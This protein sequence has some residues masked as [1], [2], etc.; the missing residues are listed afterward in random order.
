M[1]LNES[2]DPNNKKLMKLQKGDIFIVQPVKGEKENSVVTIVNG[3]EVMFSTSSKDSESRKGYRIYTTDAIEGDIL[4]FFPGKSKTR[5]K[6]QFAYIGVYD[7]NRN[8]K[9]TIQPRPPKEEK[10]EEEEEKLSPEQE[11]VREVLEQERQNIFDDFTDVEEGD[12]FSF[13]F[14]DV[15]KDE[16]GNYTGEYI[17]GTTKQA[18]FKAS[19]IYNEDIVMAKFEKIEGNDT[20][21]LEQYIGQTLSFVMDENGLFNDS[22]VG[23]SMKAF[24]NHEK[25]INFQFVYYFH[26]QKEGTEGED[27]IV[28]PKPK[29]NKDLMRLIHHKTWKDKLFG[30]E[31]KGIIPLEKIQQKFLGGEVKNRNYVRFRLDRDVVVGSGKNLRI[32][33]NDEIY[34]KMH[35]SGRIIVHGRNGKQSFHIFL[36]NT[37]KPDT[38]NVKIEARDAN[39]NKEDMGTAK[40]TMIQ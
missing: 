18:Y 16:D 37:K 28:R 24:S 23:V 30:R 34:G 15:K 21:A 20:Q 5:G 6:I 27:S 1:F 29:M 10:P 12:E 22:N 25:Q 3:H 13:M 36:K 4:Y 38:Y 9:F 8:H 35:E 31:G 39:N 26:N 7:R 33:K 19:G 17:D 2:T 11:K 14:G 40:L 32:K